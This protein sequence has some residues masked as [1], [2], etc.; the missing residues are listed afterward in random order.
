V[1]PL[2]NRPNLG[3]RVMLWIGILPAFLVLW[4]MRGVKESPVWLER[5]R[6][7]KDRQARDPLSLGRL[8]QRDLLPVTL[9]TSLVMGG[10]IFS[11][12]S[13]TAWY[14]AFL[15]GRQLT[16]LVYVLLLNIGGV[17]GAIAAGRLSETALG[18][19]GAAT[20]MMAAGVIAIPLYLFTSTPVMMWMGALAVGFFAAGSWGMVPSYLTERYPTAARAIGAGFAYHAGAA[21]GSFTPAFIGRLQDNGMPLGN[22]MAWCIAAAGVIVIALMWC[23]PETRGRHFHAAE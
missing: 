23:G 7:L 8:F 22:A 17:S 14:P 16:P 15:A 11:Y 2:V 21:L 12:H 20:V 3:W 10:F 19:R 5:Q 13:I 9:Q 4:I 6:H 18:R 1:Y